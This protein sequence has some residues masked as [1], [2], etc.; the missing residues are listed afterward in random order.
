MLQY[1]VFVP[2]WT[3]AI[4]PLLTGMIARRLDRRKPKG[5]C[6][7]CNYDRTGLAADSVC[8]E[9]GE[10]LVKVHPEKMRR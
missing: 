7:K 8:P 3:L 5:T 9:C 6:P 10:T 2:I 1:H 4:P